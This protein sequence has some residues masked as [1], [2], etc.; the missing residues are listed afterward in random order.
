MIAPKLGQPSSQSGRQGTC[1]YW[2][3][4][5][6]RASV[7]AS[8][9]TCVRVHRGHGSLVSSGSTCSAWRGIAC[10]GAGA[11]AGRLPHL[12]PVCRCRRDATHRSDGFRQSSQGQARAAYQHA[13]EHTIEY[14]LHPSIPGFPYYFLRVHTTRLLR[15]AIEVDMTCYDMI[16]CGGPGPRSSP[17]RQSSPIKAQQGSRREPQP[18]P[19]VTHLQIPFPASAAS[20]Q[21]AMKLNCSSPFH[22]PSLIACRAAPSAS[23]G[24]GPGP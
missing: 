5:L 4:E 16:W 11:R 17:S 3:L 21:P 10:G 13:G 6:T 18:Y 2:V 9:P 19:V 12:R 14:L 22:P 7:S 15:C 20:G 1:H 23:A 8:A 24:P